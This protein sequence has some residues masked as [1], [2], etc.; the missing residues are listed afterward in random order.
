MF[1]W[2]GVLSSNELHLM[3]TADSIMAGKTSDSSIKW[4][5]CYDMSARTWWMVSLMWSHYFSPNPPPP[6]NFSPPCFV[7][8][9]T[10]YKVP[11][12]GESSG[13]SCESLAWLRTPVCKIGFPCYCGQGH[14]PSL[15]KKKKRQC[16]FLFTFWKKKMQMVQSGP[17]WLVWNVWRWDSQWGTGAFL[18]NCSCISLRTG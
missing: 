16:E 9:C 1:P 15:K 12:P 14:R 6:P 10:C 7:V 4:Q 8:Q 2:L 17:G 11:L 18:A 5:L 13:W 3:K